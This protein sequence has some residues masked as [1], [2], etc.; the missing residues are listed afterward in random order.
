MSEITPPTSSILRERLQKIALVTGAASGIGFATARLFA[1]HGA[2]V[3]LVDLA[4]CRLKAAVDEI[5]YG[6][7]FRE[8]DVSSWE[9]QVALFEWVARTYGPPDIVCLNA[10]IDPELATSAT[11][12][13]MESVATNYLADEYET[14]ESTDAAGGEPQLKPPPRTIFDVNFHG[15]LYGI[16]LA[17]SYFSK[18]KGGRI[19]ITGSAVSHV[20]MP[21]ND[22]YVASKHAV[23]GLMRSTSQR[24]ELKDKG[25]SISMVAPWLTLTGLTAN[26]PLEVLASFSTEP[27]QPEDIALGI[28]YLA[29]FRDAVD[30]NGQCLWVRGKRY[31]EVEDAYGQWLGGMFAV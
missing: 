27:S 13:A 16:K 24:K 31:I 7:D 2:K 17:T 30:V 28:A 14:S 22:V 11:P 3:I 15:V 21:Y 19:V 18:F 10:G 25:I 5:G 29:I 4:T 6:C 23:L 9:Q 12:S 20:P 8:C 1:Q 26:M